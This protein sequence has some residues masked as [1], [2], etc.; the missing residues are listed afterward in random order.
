MF[1]KII[2]NSL[3]KI[4]HN[5]NSFYKNHVINLL[6]HRVLEDLPKYDYFG[7]VVTR[8][9]FIRQIRYL[10]D[11]FDC[12]FSKRHKNKNKFILTFDDGFV[13]NFNTVLPILDDFKI[14]AI[15]LIPTNYID[16]NQCIWDFKLFESFKNFNN[17]FELKINSKYIR[18]KKNKEDQIK[19]LKRVIFFIK[20]NSLKV[21][22]EIINNLYKDYSSAKLSLENRCMSSNE[23]QELSKNNM[24]IGSH[25]KSHMP[26]SKMSNQELISEMKDS[27]K[28]I[29]N[30]TGQ[31]CIY[32]SFPFGSSDD[33]NDITLKEAR[34]IGYGKCFLNIHG[35]GNSIDFAQKRVIMH[36]K[37]DLNLILNSIKS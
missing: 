29:E 37:T 20:Q 19:Y 27:K 31:N 22:K 36:K 1:K 13:D 2:I 10:K 23:I 28:T 17:D 24:F 9:T 30:I 8:E 34:N 18:F 3:K 26:F 14:K 33:F 11:N 16:T 35:L 32:I 4:S 12:F 5:Y 15:F 21:Q 6:Y 25:S 7:T